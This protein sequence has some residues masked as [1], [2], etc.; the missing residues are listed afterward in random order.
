MFDCDIVVA[1]ER[2]TCGH[3]VVGEGN[4]FCETH[5]RVMEK[6]YPQGWRYYPGDV[7]SHGRYVGGSGADW[8]CGPCEMGE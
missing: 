7:C 2:I 8:M 1:G 5:N 3:W 6:R 4:V